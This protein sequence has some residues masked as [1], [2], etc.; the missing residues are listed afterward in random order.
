MQDILSLILYI[1]VYTHIHIY[2]HTLC[3]LQKIVWKQ[4]KLVGL[5]FVL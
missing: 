2:A 1:C 3:L 4:V 5:A